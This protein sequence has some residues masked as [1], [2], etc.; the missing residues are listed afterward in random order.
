MH[1]LFS[2]IQDKLLSPKY[3]GLSETNKVVKYDIVERMQQVKKRQLAYD[4]DVLTIDNGVK[5]PVS[6]QKGIW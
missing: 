3:Y 6:V 5:Y 4:S 2:F 1:S